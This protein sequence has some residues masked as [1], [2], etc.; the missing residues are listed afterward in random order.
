MSVYDV[1]IV[2]GGAAGLNAALMLGRA[3]RRIAVVDGG[4]PRNAPATAMHGFLS[5]DGMPP[6]ELL[7]AGR[8]ELESYGGEIIDGEVTGIDAG[9]YVRLG[10]GRVLK[11]RR[12]LVATGLT[13]VLPD[14][15]G[16]RE[17]F[18]RDV[19]H[20]PYCHGYEVRDRPLGVIGSLHHAYLV[21]QWSPDLVFFS[22]GTEVSLEDR[23][24]LS[25]RGVKVV[26]GKVVR[27]AVTDDRLSA[28]ELADGRTVERSALFVAPKMVPN[29]RLLK[30]LGCVA[31]DNGV[32][33]VDAVGRTSEFGVFAAGNSVTPMATVIG[34]ASAGAQAGAF[35]NA[36]LVEEDFADALDRS[37]AGTFGPEME[38]RVSRL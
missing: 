27:V 34:A 17:R 4:Q 28:V 1:V 24:K 18:G 12:V 35:I 31:D 22:N 37:R 10:D 29:D 32:V 38:R 7:A 6:R 11:A 13:D 36:E 33:R 26:D 23:E 3:R 15:A 25:A 2:G 9:F 14:I 19:L 20:C 16:L 8:A 21:R 30:D 5:R